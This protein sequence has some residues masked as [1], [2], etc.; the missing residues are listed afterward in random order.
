MSTQRRVLLTAMAL[1][2]SAAMQTGAQPPGMGLGGLRM[3]VTE[4]YFGITTDGTLV[5]GLF[6]IQLTGVSTAPVREAAVAFLD[7]LTQAQ[8]DEATFAVDD[9][10]WRTW[11]NISGGDR[12]GLAFAEMTEAQRQAG[13]ELLR[14]ALSPKG[15]E[16]TRNIMRLNAHLAELVSNFERYGEL[17]YYLTFMGDPS[18]TEPWG[19]QLDGHHL[20]V[21]YFVLGDQ[22]VMTPTFMGSE[23]VSA[24]SGRYAGTA[25]LQ[26]EQDQGTALMASL[27]PSQR[28][29][30]LL[31]EEKRFGNN[32]G[33]QFNDNFM[34]D[35]AGIRSIALTESQRTALVDLIALYID[36]MGEGHAKVRMAE[37]MDYIDETYFAWAGEVGPEA[38]FYYR[39]HSPVILIEFDHQGPVALRGNQPMGGPPTRRHVH[40]VVRTPNGNDYGKSLLQQHYQAHRYDLNHGHINASLS[41]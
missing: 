26:T 36:N 27:D 12:Q 15:Y 40:T 9:S 17:E 2:L 37:V 30:A 20:V 38:V 16:T 18:G 25:V 29:M 35:Y 10:E 21:N 4:P 3:A 33:E 31:P 23:P 13:Y 24:E 14:I 1:A 22:V 8:K 39:I 6:P 34:L 41:R 19:W 28:E 32:H 5:D 11:F 7:G